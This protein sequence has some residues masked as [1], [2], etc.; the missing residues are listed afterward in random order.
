M[1][2][3]TQKSAKEVMLNSLQVNQSAIVGVTLSKDGSEYRLHIATKYSKGGNGEPSAWSVLSENSKYDNASYAYA[4]VPVSVANLATF[5]ISTEGVTAGVM[6]E[7]LL[8]N[9]SINGKNIYVKVTDVLFSDYKGDKTKL[10]ENDYV[11][12]P[13]TKARSKAN[14]QDVIRRK[15]VTLGEVKHAFI[16]LDR[17]TASAPKMQAVVTGFVEEGAM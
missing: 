16:Q 11:V 8:A 6:K 4:F 1:E 17:I 15:A 3:Q 14:G 5:G 7:V 9:P 12:N 2:T 13:T 10:T